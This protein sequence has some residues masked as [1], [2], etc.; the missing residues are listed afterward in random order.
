VQG[1]QGT[2]RGDQEN[3][4]Y[5]ADVR[6][7]TVRH[8]I[9]APLTHPARAPHGVF[10]DVLALHWRSKQDAILQQ[11]ADWRIERGLVNQVTE[12]LGKLN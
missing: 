8:A 4:R 2:A 3:A 12:A 7:N 5:N 11:L 10:K 9:L 6:K 1:L